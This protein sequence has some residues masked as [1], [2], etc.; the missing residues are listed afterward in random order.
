MSIFKLAKG[1]K[2]ILMFLSFVNYVCPVCI[3]Q[4]KA[5]F[6]N[7]P[8]NFLTFLKFLL[9]LHQEGQPGWLLLNHWATHGPP[10]QS[11]KKYKMSKSFKGHNMYSLKI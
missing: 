3:F 6:L 2:H 5:L 1:N 11:L 9:K 8:S 4:M 10:K 7:L